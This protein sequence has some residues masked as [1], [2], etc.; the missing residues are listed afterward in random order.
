MTNEPEKINEEV[1]TEE[2][3]DNLEVNDPYTNTCT[4]CEG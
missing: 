2:E 3:L 4:S 1:E